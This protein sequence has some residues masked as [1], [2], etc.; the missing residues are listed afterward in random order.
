MLEAITLHAKES[1]TEP[2]V[3]FLGDVIDRGRDSCDAM[4]MVVD[5]LKRWP[6]SEFILGNHEEFLLKVLR[7][8][9]GAPAALQKWA[10]QGGRETLESYYLENS[11]TIGDLIES[12]ETT[13]AEH[14]AVWT[15]ASA[16]IVDRR[17]AFVHAGIDPSRAIDDQTER[18]L[19]WIRDPFLDHDAP[20]SHVIVHGH[21]VTPEQLPVVTRNRIS[22]DTGAYGTGRLTCLVVSPDQET[23]TFLATTPNTWPIAVE[24]LRIFSLGDIPQD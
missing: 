14:L 6:K 13:H 4:E 18:D 11:R 3:I 17:L 16:I 10:F 7:N 21:T 19:R 8:D 24:T 23:L 9:E 22:I 2:R 1:G 15:R 12:F 20:L 5:T